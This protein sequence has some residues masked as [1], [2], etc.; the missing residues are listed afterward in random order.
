MAIGGLSSCAAVAT[1]DYMDDGKTPDISELALC[2]F[3]GIF[4]AGKGFLEKTA[5]KM[6][7][8]F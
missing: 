2:S 4:G 7:A 1:T 6:G 5:M 8:S 3:G